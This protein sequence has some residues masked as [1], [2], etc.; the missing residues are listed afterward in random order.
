M[1]NKKS[2]KSTLLM[3]VIMSSPGPLVVGLGLLVGQSSTQVADFVRRSIELL[4][5]ILSFVVYCITTKDDVINE[6]KKKKYEKITNIF[7][8]IAMIVSGIIM[9]IL[10]FNSTTEDK[11]NVIPGLAIAIL[12]FVANSIFW[13]KYTKLSKET[14]NNILK[15]QSK[16]YRAKTFVDFSVMIALGVVLLST[17]PTTCYYF[18]LIGTI[19]VS[20]YLFLT[21]VKSLIDELKKSS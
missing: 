21:G 16:L 8:S 10:A 1:S 6:F 7:V 11:G 13:F 17:N 4:A 15:I 2:G 18:D 3:S 19:I 9:F 20:I 14:N 12:G 5:I